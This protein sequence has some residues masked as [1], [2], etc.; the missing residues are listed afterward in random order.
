[1]R[2]AVTDT[3]KYYDI[4]RYKTKI[5]NLHARRRAKV[6]LDTHAKDNMEDE[7]PSLYHVI[8]QRRSR[9][10]REIKEIKDAEVMTY[11]RMQD[12]RNTFVQHM[13]HK[14]SPIA[15]DKKD[16]KD[17]LSYIPPVSPTTCATQLEAPINTDEVQ[18]ALRAGARHGA[19]GI[20][21]L[22]L[23]FHTANWETIKMDLTE[24]LNHMFQQN[25]IPPRLKQGIII[26]LPKSQESCTPDDF[27]P[28]SL[29]NTEYKLPFRILASRLRPILAEQLTSSQYCGV[30]VKSIYDTLEEIR[31]IIGQYE[32]KKKQLCLLT[33]DFKQAFD[34]FSQQ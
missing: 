26:C 28:I 5:V 20:D 9:E 8:Q 6:L 12:I 19:P 7:E 10:M 34:R 17:L 25:H 33:L 30:P 27:R 1:M 16:I 15:V 24:L 2:R 32:N 31:D 11:T 29:L 4:Q 21:G 18:S 22:S 3:D 14:F 13:A 23:E